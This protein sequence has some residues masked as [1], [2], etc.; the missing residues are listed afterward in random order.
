MMTAKIKPKNAALYDDWKHCIA[1]LP[2]DT[3]VK[4]TDNNP[5]YLGLWADKRYTQVNWDG[6]I[7]YVLNEQL[8]EVESNAK[9]N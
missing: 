7:G 2:K 5:A 6:Q 8:E 4:I 9:N 3:K 1:Y